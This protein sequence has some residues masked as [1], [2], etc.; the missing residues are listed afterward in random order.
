MEIRLVK[1][2]QYRSTVAQIAE[3]ATQDQKVLGSIP[4]WIQWD[5]ASKYTTYLFCVFVADDHDVWY[6][7]THI[8]LWW[9]DITQI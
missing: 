2:L 1:V 7:R 6:D 3:Q 9:R 5:F 8:P 4:A